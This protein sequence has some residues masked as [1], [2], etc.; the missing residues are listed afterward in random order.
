M[1]KSFHDL[2]SEVRTKFKEFRSDEQRNK[3]CHFDYRPLSEEDRNQEFFEAYR[4]QYGRAVVKYFDHTKGD[5]LAYPKS[6]RWSDN[7]GQKRFFE[8]A[9]I[10]A[11]MLNAT[12]DIYCRVL[13]DFYATKIGKPSLATPENMRNEY[14][15]MHAIEKVGEEREGRIIF[16][17]HSAYHVASFE[18]LEFQ[19]QYGEYLIEAIKRKAAPEY[20][21]AR[22]LF[23]FE[24]LGVERAIH[25][26]GLELVE[27]A[28]VI[29][30]SI[31]YDR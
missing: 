25:E 4:R 23:E 12:Y 11:D 1:E 13:F 3:S 18:G 20:A 21:L 26:F 29:S 22:A 14:A 16:P 6:K 8:Q 17:S 28:L 5:K 24:V 15:I 10:A 30:V 31:C 9:R 27:R 2:A 19:S 7:A